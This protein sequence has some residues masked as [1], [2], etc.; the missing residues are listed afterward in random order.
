[1]FI[2]EL[3]LFALVASP[4]VSQTFRRYLGES[5][6]QNTQRLKL[7]FIFL[8]NFCLTT[9]NFFLTLPLCQSSFLRLPLIPLLLSL[10]L[11]ANQKLP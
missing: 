4:H 2:P 7:S 11:G 6:Y 10:F 8:A 5:S 1:M 9:P 3:V